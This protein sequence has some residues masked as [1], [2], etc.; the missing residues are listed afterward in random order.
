METV[1]FLLVVVVVILLAA[2]WSANRYYKGEQ[3]IKKHIKNGDIIPSFLEDNDEYICGCDTY[4]EPKAAKYP[5]SKNECYVDTKRAETYKYPINKDENFIMTS[6]YMEE[7]GEFPGIDGQHFKLPL[8][9]SFEN[10]D[11]IYVDLKN[12]PV[13]HVTEEP[14][15]FETEENC[16]GITEYYTHTVE[17]MV[18]KTFDFYPKKYLLPGSIYFKM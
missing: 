8:I 5:L 14:I 15:I 3:K 6:K 16:G 9:K 1:I 10:G 17:M 11:C 2:S 12:S 7:A 18:N 4:D 13:L